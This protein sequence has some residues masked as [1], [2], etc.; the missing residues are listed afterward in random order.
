MEDGQIVEHGSHSQLLAAR[1][2]YARLYELQAE[3]YR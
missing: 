2:A 1:G 3:R